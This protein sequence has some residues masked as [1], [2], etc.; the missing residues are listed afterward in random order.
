MY[1]WL[2]LA[3]L[4]AIKSFFILILQTTH[5]IIYSFSPASFMLFPELSPSSSLL[6][7]FSLHNQ[8]IRVLLVDLGRIL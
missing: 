4:E 7:L 8:I 6:S 3:E 1:L 5:R 2:S